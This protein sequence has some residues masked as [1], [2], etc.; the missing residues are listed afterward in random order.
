ME[1]PWLDPERKMI[2]ND[3]RRIDR[4]VASYSQ[5]ISGF[6]SDYNRRVGSNLWAQYS[7]PFGSTLRATGSVNYVYQA[8]WQYIWTWLGASQIGLV[9]VLLNTRLKREEITYQ[10]KQSES[11]AVVIPGTGAFR[12]FLGD[13]LAICP[14][15]ANGSLATGYAKDYYYDARLADNPPPFFP[16]TGGYDRISWIR[17]ANQS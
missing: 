10:L 1:S 8:P 6:M 17:T 16:T 14:E 7:L 3:V 5:A 4:T 12:D 13:L 11:A 15:A 2:A 9:S